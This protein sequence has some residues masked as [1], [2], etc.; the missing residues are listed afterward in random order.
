LG[1]FPIAFNGKNWLLTLKG[2]QDLKTGNFTSKS[3]ISI[4]CNGLKEISLDGNLKVSR[5]VLLPIK[6]DG[7]YVCDGVA[8]PFP[9]NTDDIKDSPCYVSTDFTVQAKGWND[10]LLEVDIPDFEMVGLK[11]W[12]FNID[13]AVLDL[14]DT[15]NAENIAFPEAY[16]QLLPQGNRNLWR[17]VYAKQVKII[18]PK[19]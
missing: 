12:G 14:S 3:F 5:N 6:E 10:V 2:G 1:N 18:L 13:K 9:E 19:S 8:V 11:G 17:G 4:D 7:T 15:R 16:N